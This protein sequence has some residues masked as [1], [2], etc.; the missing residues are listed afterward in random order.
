MTVSTKTFI[1]IT[2]AGLAAQVNAFLAPLITTASVFVVQCSI[3]MN[4]LERRGAAQYQCTIT[5]TT[6]GSPPSLA[7]PFTLQFE[8]AGS[9]AAFDAA[10]AAFLLTAAAAYSIGWR[11]ISDVRDPS[12]LPMV[13][14]WTLANATAGAGANYAPL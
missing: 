11:V 12:L 10:T 6:G 4:A 5:T 7:T 13:L 3:I 9:A 14:G 2:T 1:D 8:Q